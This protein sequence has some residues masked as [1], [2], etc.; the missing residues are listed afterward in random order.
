MFSEEDTSFEKHTSL[1]RKSPN[2]K[3]RA[4]TK[5]VPFL[6]RRSGVITATP[7]D[8]LSGQNALTIFTE[9]TLP[10]VHG[11]RSCESQPRSA[12]QLNFQQLR[13]LATG[14]VKEIVHIRSVDALDEVLN[15][16]GGLTHEQLENLS[17]FP[18]KYEGTRLLLRSTGIS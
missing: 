13:I 3:F 6:G 17:P 7:V 15:R 5:L 16:S 8:N 1:G 12:R 18:S 2:F 10:S 4:S 14:H 11:S 9:I